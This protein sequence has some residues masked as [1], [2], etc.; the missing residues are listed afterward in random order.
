MTRTLIS[1]I[2]LSV[3]VHAFLFWKARKPAAVI[4]LSYLSNYQYTEQTNI[5]DAYKSPCDI[6]FIGDSHIYKCHWDELLGMPVCNRGIG[7]DIAEGVYRRI[8]DIIQARPKV[9]FIG[10]GSND[11]EMKVPLDSTIMYFK[12]IVD[13][14]KASGIKPVIMLVTPVSVSYPNKEFNKEIL[15]LNRRL[16]LLGSCI[17]INVQPVDIQPDG[18]HLKASGY[19]KWKGTILQFLPQTKTQ[20]NKPQNRVKNGHNIL[21]INKSIPLA[22]I[23]Y[24]IPSS[25]ITTLPIQRSM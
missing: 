5:F 14:L 17:S 3:A 15:E 4:S 11:I 1:I 12:S 8:G 24:S 10:A 23:Y 9:C 25:H 7:S 16:S 22:T 18:I 19:E 2:I 6:A 13:T 20:T 21:N